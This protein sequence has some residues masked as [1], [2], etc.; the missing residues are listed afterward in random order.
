MRTVR[1]VDIADDHIGDV[2]LQPVH[3]AHRETCGEC[4]ALRARSF[5]GVGAARSLL[6]MP[7]QYRLL[8]LLLALAL[9]L[10]VPR[11]L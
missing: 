4:A 1:T 6:L 5:V 8:V 10:I 11:H 3:D 7:E 2:H 9:G